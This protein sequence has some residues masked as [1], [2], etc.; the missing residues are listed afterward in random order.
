[1]LHSL[2]DSAEAVLNFYRSFFL[3][4]MYSFFKTISKLI[5]NN[6]KNDK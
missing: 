4:L 1:M 3:I 5:S 2:V 6:P